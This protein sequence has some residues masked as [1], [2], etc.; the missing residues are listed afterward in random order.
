MW[1]AEAP[2]TRSGVS[3][4]GSCALD[5]D[6]VVTESLPLLE[7]H[8]A[9]NLSRSA[10][11]RSQRR[12]LGRSVPRGRSRARPPS[13]AS[14]SVAAARSA[15]W[16]DFMR[17]D[18]A[19]EQLLEPDAPSGP[20][21]TRPRRR[22]CAPPPRRRAA[23]IS[24]T[25]ASIR[26]RSSSRSVARPTS[27][28]GCRS[29]RPHPR[30]DAAV[31][32]EPRSSVNRA[33][34]LA[35]LGCTPDASSSGELGVKR[36]GAALCDLA[37]DLGANVGWHRRSHLELG[38]RRTQVQAGAADDDRPPPAA[39]SCVDLAWASSAKRPAVNSPSTGTNAEQAVLE[40]RLL[41][42][43]RRRR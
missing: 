36:L 38:Q 7:A 26:S 19:R 14:R 10:A 3:S 22:R 4:H 35:S 18:V 32:P 43:G 20:C 30:R 17:L 5:D 29:P 16:A 37:L 31:D 41:C 9:Q 13:F 21:A 27:S 33:T 24:S 40:S 11:R 39:S 28:V 6:V 23:I 12:R 34:R 1:L 25:R 42:R 8:A 15:R 2:R